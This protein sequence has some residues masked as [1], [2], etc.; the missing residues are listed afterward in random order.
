MPLFKTAIS[1]EVSDKGGH[2]FKVCACEYFD[3]VIYFVGCFF[4][5]D[6]KQKTVFV[7]SSTFKNNKLAF[8]SKNI[9]FGSM[10]KNIS[11]THEDVIDYRKK[12][13]MIS[14][15]IAGEEAIKAGKEKYLPSP[16]ADTNTEYAKNRFNSYIQR[17]VFYN[18][19]GRTLSSLVGQVFSK[20][21]E[22]DLPTDLD[23][24]K[25]NID[26]AGT[27]IEQQAKA[28]LSVIM[29]KG[30]CGLLSD[31]PATSGES[32]TRQ[33][34]ETMRIR[35]RVMLV[36][37]EDIINWRVTVIGG[38]SVLSL[39]VLQESTI[40]EDDGYEFK[41]EPRW[42]EMRLIATDET[43]ANFAVQ[44]TVWRKL[45][46]AINGEEFEIVEGFPV[47][48]MD[49]AG[50]PLDRIPFEF[51]GSTNNEPQID[52][53]PLLDLANLNIAHYHNSADYE[54]GVFVSGQDQL[55]LV[56][57]TQE[58]TD[59]N[60][61][62]G[63]KLGARNAIPL[64]KDMDAKLLHTDPNNI[65]SEAMKH[66][67]DQMKSI[68][69]KLIEPTATKGTATEAIIE[70][71]SETSILSSAAKNVSLAYRKAL[72]N[73]SRFVS[74]V[75]P[76]TIIYQLNSDFAAAMATPQERAQILA[77]WQGGLITFVEA[78][79]QLRKIGVATE[80]DEVAKAQMEDIIF[81]VEPV[82]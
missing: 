8:C 37:P 66:K 60:F 75:D 76:L 49:Y 17:S 62:G 22:I 48:L 78:R 70:E 61:K 64:G 4:G 32:T 77:E 27:S 23:R 12:W 28:T 42:R 39:I 80:D 54:E 71:S 74:D 9:D 65:A 21:S 20:D 35:P 3:G 56:G 7:F 59:K 11:F 33:D 53:P 2:T 13:S 34:I 6:I 73:A 31:F 69:A 10:P 40:T 82:N 67:E 38:E 55:V 25:G 44:V 68:G 50:R 30:H 1:A 18:V 46:K 26:G 79:T 5:H 81:P 16:S 51:V 72:Y 29:S 36:M 52:K 43:E 19:I 57:L 41:T 24:Y 58:W 15:C 47:T 14:D 63:L 45:E